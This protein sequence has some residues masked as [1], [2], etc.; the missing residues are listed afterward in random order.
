[1]ALRFDYNEVLIEFIK[2]RLTASRGARGGK[3]RPLSKM[4]WAYG[5]SKGSSCW[6]VL[7]T[8]W[9]GF[10]KELLDQGVTLV[11]PLAHPKAKTG[12]FFPHLNGEQKWDSKRCE[13]R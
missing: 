8:Y 6:W 11:G 12:G 10:R 3:G 1:V 13:W 5:W 7:G 2:K 9:E 4:A